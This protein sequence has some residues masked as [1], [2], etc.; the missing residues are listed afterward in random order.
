[1]TKEHIFNLHVFLWKLFFLIYYQAKYPVNS[2]CHMEY[3][4]ESQHRQ[5]QELKSCDLKLDTVYKVA[6]EVLPTPPDGCQV[7]A[8]S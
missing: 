3:D 6:D 5:N 1:M 7:T 4:Q 2:M 8:V